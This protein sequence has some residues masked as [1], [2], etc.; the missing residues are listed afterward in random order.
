[1]VFEQYGVA[2]QHPAALMFLASERT[3][4]EA[5]GTTGLRLQGYL[6]VMQ[7]FFT[8]S[9]AIQHLQMKAFTQG[10]CGVAMAGAFPFVRHR[11][12]R[13]PSKW[14]FL[15]YPGPTAF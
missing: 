15:S 8:R 7:T 2:A 4:R 1:M 5:A 14:S 3:L 13:K 6:A 12:T 10:N 11:K 9:F